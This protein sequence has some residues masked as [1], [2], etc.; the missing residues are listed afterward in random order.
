MRVLFRV[1]G[2]P[3][4]GLGHL[5]RT[6]ALAGALRSRG[7]E[8]L[9]AAAMEEEAEAA[10][11]G[12]RFEV[13]QVEWN[14]LNQSVLRRLRG[15]SLGKTRLAVRSVLLQGVLTERSARLPDHLQGLRGAVDRVRAVAIR[16]GMDLASL[17]LRAALDQPAVT[18][19][20]VGAST[21]AEVGWASA[22]A[23]GQ[24]LT[25]K[26]P[27]EIEDLDQ[28]YL[29]LVDPRSWPAST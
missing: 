3:D 9:F 1:E 23:R 27:R 19:V 2:G 12:G 14:V 28:G 22:A 21:V 7:A 6:R 18:W 5:V 10:V 4:L 11:S 20:V 24:P 8:S 15:S 13:V 17:A 29:P 26:Q 16:M 25:A